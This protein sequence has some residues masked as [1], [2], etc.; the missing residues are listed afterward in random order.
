M[1]DIISTKDGS[2]TLKSNQFDALYHSINGAVQE[3]QIVF[4]EAALYHKATTT[5]PLSILEIGLGTGLNAFMTYLEAQKQGWNIQYTGMEVY[6][7]EEA[8]A[9]A[10]N[11]P[12]LLEASEEDTAL[13]LQLHQRE[14]AMTALTPFFSFE[15]KVQSFES[16]EVVEQYDIVYYDAFAPSIQPHLWEKE[17]LTR[18][19][20]ALKP[21]GVLTTY[22]AQGAFKRTLKAIGFTLEGL[23]GPAGK[24]EMTRATKANS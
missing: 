19:Y 20:N 9:R 5:D 21:N 14:E 2:N 6:P 11:Y 12:H 23:P 17:Q 13:F 4:I 10:L 16:L 1:A 7:I 18:I 24:R 8:T 22:C 3:S 15:K